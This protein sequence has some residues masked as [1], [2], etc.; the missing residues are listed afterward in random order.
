MAWRV[1]LL[2][3]NRVEVK[4]LG[5]HHECFTGFAAQWFQVGAI[6]LFGLHDSMP[7]CAAARCGTGAAGLGCIREMGIGPGDSVANRRTRPGRKG[8]ITLEIQKSPPPT[9]RPGTNLHR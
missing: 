5:S 9:A 2:E 3:S 7:A 6:V 8:P 4:D 1:V